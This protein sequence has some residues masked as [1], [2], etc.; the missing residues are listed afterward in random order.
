MSFAASFAI[1]KMYHKIN[2]K[3]NQSGRVISFYPVYYLF[4]LSLKA[5]TVIKED[6]VPTYGQTVVPKTVFVHL[7]DNDPMS[8][9]NLHMT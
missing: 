4:V 6:S 5:G 3:K 7:P 2:G 8:V 1:L 9:R